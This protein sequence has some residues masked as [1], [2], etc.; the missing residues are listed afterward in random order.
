M[1]IGIILIIAVFVMTF[2]TYTMAFNTETENYT[3]NTTGITSGG[4]KVNT[5]TYSSL[6]SISQFAT[7]GISSSNFISCQG[8]YCNSSLVSEIIS[9][10]GSTVAIEGDNTL[11][12]VAKFT[13]SRIA[14]SNVGGKIWVEKSPGVYD[15][16]TLCTSNST[17]HCSI[18][19]NPDCSYSGGFANVIAGIF[20]SFY[21]DTN[22]TPKTII[23]DRSSECD[24]DVTFTMQFSIDGGTN[25]DVN[26][27]GSGRGYYT[28][29]QLAN[30]YACVQGNSTASNPTLGIVFGGESLRYVNVTQNGTRNIVQMSQSGNNNRFIIPVSTG[31]CSVVS[32]KASS[33]SS[34]EITSSPFV[35]FGDA[36][37]NPLELSLL[38]NTINIK[39][40]F[41]SLGN[42]KISIKKTDAEDIEITRG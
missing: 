7:R 2:S 37:E 3:S 9:G 8:I 1:R 20:N 21:D 23:I 19:F 27:G 13:D 15:S 28:G 16:G 12:I 30:K 35:S 10:N 22:S 6:T 5:S 42:F 29:S 4:Q 31:S 36:V 18:D 34:S 41:S 38:Y 32:S 24:A 40:N 33:V 17:G 25:D 14:L 39:G 11:K 26:I